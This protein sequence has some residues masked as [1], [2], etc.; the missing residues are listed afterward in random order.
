MNKKQFIIAV[1]SIV[2][3]ALAV[4]FTFSFSAAN[5]PASQKWEYLIVSP[6]KVYWC[7]ESVNLD[8]PPG[9][10]KADVSEATGFKAEAVEQEQLLDRVGQQGWELVA[11]VGI[12]GGD[13]E[14]VFKR[15]IR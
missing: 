14:F 12:L 6:G 3:V 15:P 1:L 2:L 10:A 9:A 7:G 8:C 13:Q 4:A 11:I 5:N